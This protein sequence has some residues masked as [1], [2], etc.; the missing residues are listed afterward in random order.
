MILAISPLIVSPGWPRK[1]ERPVANNRANGT[2]ASRRLK[3]MPAARKKMLS[4]AL[5]SQIRLP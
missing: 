4:S 2:A 1:Y 5:L 3:E